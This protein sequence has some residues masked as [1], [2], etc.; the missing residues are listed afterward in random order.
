MTYICRLKL[1]YPHFTSLPEHAGTE[2][3][4]SVVSFQSMLQ[5]TQVI[6]VSPYV[7][8]VPLKA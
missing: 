5:S 2:T 7:A 4:M 1:T 8:S 6:Y 3:D